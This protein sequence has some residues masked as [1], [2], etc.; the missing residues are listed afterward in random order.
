MQEL[1]HSDGV[2]IEDFSCMVSQDCGASKGCLVRGRQKWSGASHMSTAKIVNQIYIY[3]D[4]GSECSLL[5]IQNN[6]Q[7]SDMH[8]SMAF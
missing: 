1:Q 6:A 4:S 2:E 8:G 5:E 7:S 3:E